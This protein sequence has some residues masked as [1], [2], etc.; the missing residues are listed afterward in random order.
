MTANVINSEN[1]NI[2]NPFSR[3]I[4]IDHLKKNGLFT[5]DSAANHLIDRMVTSGSIKRIGRNQY[6]I[7]S[8]LNE[9][10]FPYSEISLE[11]AAK[12]KTTH[13]YLDFRIFELVQLNEFVNHQIAHNIIFVYVEK[14]LEGDVFVTLNENHSVS[15]LI[16][17]DADTLFRYLSDDIIVISSLPSESPKGNP[18]FWTTC[19]EKMLVDIAVDKLLSKVVYHGEYPEIYREAFRK[20]RINRNKMMRYARRRGAEKKYKSFLVQE[21]N[22]TEDI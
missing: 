20:Y 11:I 13:P 7:G 2:I 22:I 1:M 6:M 21:A 15:V 5:T 10:S 18:E 19:L 8:D 4:F 16:K 9:Y 14:G 17:P 12:I 3:S